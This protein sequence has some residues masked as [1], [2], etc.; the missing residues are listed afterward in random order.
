VTCR[1]LGRAK[2]KGLGL[3]LESWSLRLWHLDRWALE[4]GIGFED[5]LLSSHDGV[6]MQPLVAGNWS[7]SL[8][9]VKSEEMLLPG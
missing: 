9:K 7:R 6:A 5:T 8:L 4:G 1:E 2:E 3:A